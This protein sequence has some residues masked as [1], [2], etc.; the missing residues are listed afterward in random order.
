MAGGEGA[1]LA[2][3]LKPVEGNLLAG[4][5]AGPYVY[6]AV[7]RDK[8]KDASAEYKVPFEVSR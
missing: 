8:L 6:L 1:R 7:L 2:G 3:A 5:P 4:L